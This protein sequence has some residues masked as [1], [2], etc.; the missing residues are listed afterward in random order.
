MPKTNTYFP[1]TVLRGQK[2]EIQVLVVAPWHVQKHVKSRS[3]RSLKKAWTPRN[4][5]KES[6]RYRWNIYKYQ[7]GALFSSSQTVKVKLCGS[8]RDNLHVCYD[9]AGQ[10]PCG[11]HNQ[12]VY[13]FKEEVLILHS[14]VIWIKIVVGSWGVSFSFHSWESAPL[15]SPL[16][17]REPASCFPAWSDSISW[18][19]VLTYAGWAASG[20]QTSR[21]WKITLSLMAN[22]AGSSPAS[23]SDKS[24]QGCIQTRIWTY[25]SDGR[26]VR[27]GSKG[28]D[29]VLF[30]EF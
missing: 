6:C 26:E 7:R 3:K 8:G 10:T 18:R 9:W 19:L 23:P 17:L 14:L 1:G 25:G 2:L 22:R 15:C 5:E 4:R 12:D 20:M 21:C 27:R 29:S 24:R 11:Q 28:N 13:V 30:P 16:G